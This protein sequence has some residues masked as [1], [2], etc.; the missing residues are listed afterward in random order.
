MLCSRVEMEGVVPSVAVVVCPASFFNEY[1]L[2]AA[3]V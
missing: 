3:A 1:L 2:P